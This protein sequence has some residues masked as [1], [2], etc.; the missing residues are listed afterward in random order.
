MFVGILH[1]I[2][3]IILL[4]GIHGDLTIGIIITDIIRIGIL[5][6]TDTIEIVVIIV[7]RC[8]EII[9]TIE[10][11]PTLL[12]LEIIEVLEDTI[13]LILDLKPEKTVQQQLHAEIKIA[14]AQHFLQ[15]E[16]QAQ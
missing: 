8:I 10:T 3:V 11:A 7:T 2:G 15:Q 1:G 9:I 6:I 13:T 14:H 5:I 4:I 12:L 16:I